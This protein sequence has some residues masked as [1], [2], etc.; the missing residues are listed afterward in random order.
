MKKIFFQFVFLFLIA[1]TVFSQVPD[2]TKPGKNK[3]NVIE[4]R[5]LMDASRSNRNV[6]VKIHYPV[7]KGIYPA[8]V[9]SHGAGGSWDGH[10]GLAHFLASYGYVV[11]CVEHVGSNTAVL[12]KSI[13]LMHNVNAMIHDANEVMNRPKDISFAIDQLKKWNESQRELNGKIDLQNIGVLGHSFGAYTSMVIA[14]I[15]PALQWIRPAVKPGSGLGSDLSDKRVKACVALSPQGAEEPFFIE[16][17]FLTLKSPLM[18]I[19]GTKDK[20][21]GNT[22]PINRYNSFS[23]WPAANGIHKFVWLENAAHNDFSDNEG[24]GTHNFYSPNRK[25]V[26]KVVRA[27]VLIFFNYHL[28]GNKTIID[29]LSTNGLQSY[30][31]GKITNIEVR[32]K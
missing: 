16:E 26:S 13:R 12:K 2:F 18:G 21:M 1:C 8:I 19:S 29:H 27:A 15:R 9:I 32:S 3:V 7:E 20:I 31:N 6:P 23:L 14:G 17:S 4:F 25:D 10:Y 11:L 24:S 22:A 5:N 30:L 28:K